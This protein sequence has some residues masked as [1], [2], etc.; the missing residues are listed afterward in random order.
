MISI[1]NGYG[2]FV[3]LFTDL[4]QLARAD[5]F[6]GTFTSNVGR[7]VMV[8]REGFQKERTSAISLDKKYWFSGRKQRLV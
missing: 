4:H 7:M 3:Y 6:V 5:V 8:L 1:S 2:S